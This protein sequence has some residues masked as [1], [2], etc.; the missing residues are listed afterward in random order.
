MNGKIVAIV[1]LI[2]GLLAG[3]GLYYTQV[4]AFYEPVPA[5]VEDVQL[6]GVVSG[7]S[8]PV[9]H[10]NF[11]G[12]D[13][14]SSPLRYRA[15]YDVP[16]P[17]MTLAETYLIYAEPVPLVGP[18]WFDCF[19]AGEID[20]ALSTG[21]AV[22]F[23]GEENVVYGIDRVVAVFHDGRARAWHQINR[24][25]RAVYDGYAAPEGCPEPPERNE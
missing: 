6:M 11:Q 24:C 23:L 18:S 5:Q 2:S 21:A 8:E 10:E 1:L 7:M 22:A 12:I 19:D 20:E 13:A 15:C 4:Y 25:G 16:V 9:P 3:A 17:L 14:D